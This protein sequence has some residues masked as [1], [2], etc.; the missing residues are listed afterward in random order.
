MLQFILYFCENLRAMQTEKI[1]ELLDKF[2]SAC[3]EVAAVE[4]WSARE[5]QEILGYKDWRNFEKVLKKAK[6]TCQN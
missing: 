1:K 4:C 5:L 2:E 3:Y 6:E